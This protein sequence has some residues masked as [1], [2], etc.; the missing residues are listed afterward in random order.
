M[1]IVTG[2]RDVPDPL[3]GLVS[4]L[5][6]YSQVSNSEATTGEHRHLELHSNWWFLPRLLV[7][8]LGEVGDGCQNLLLITLKLFN[9]PEYCGFVRLVLAFA[10]ARRKH[11]HLR[12]V[13]RHRYLD[14]NVVCIISALE[15]RA[16][17][18]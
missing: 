3:L 15:Y 7:F 11:L 8:G 10:T 13:R 12:R 2:F 16:N 4:A 6:L 17:L 9:S 14:D 5:L 1:R 18:N